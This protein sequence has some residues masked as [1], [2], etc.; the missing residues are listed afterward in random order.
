MRNDDLP[1]RTPHSAFRTPHSRAALVDA[2]AGEHRLRRQALAEQREAERWMARATFAEERGLLELASSARTRAARHAR[3]ASLLSQRAEEMRAEVQRLRDAL[4]ATQ[5][6]G[7]APPPGPS[8]E[9]RFAALELEAEL[10]RIRLANRGDAAPPQP[11]EPQKE[12]E[13]S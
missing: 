6:A 1:A 13:V 12:M 3:M 10:D 11:S 2:L 5:G 8:L 4:A 7:R 9:G